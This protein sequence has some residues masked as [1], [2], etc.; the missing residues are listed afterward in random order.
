MLQLLKIELKLIV[1]NSWIRQVVIYYFYAE[2]VIILFI[3]KK[4][5]IEIRK[6]I[7]PSFEYIIF[8]FSQ[9]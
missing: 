8:S 6:N 9:K 2:N 3:K 1:F 7:C 5:I 4:K